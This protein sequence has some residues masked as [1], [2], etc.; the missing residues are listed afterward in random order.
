ML[1]KSVED[2]IKKYTPQFYALF[3]AQEDKKIMSNTFLLL[4]LLRCNSIMI[5][6]KAVII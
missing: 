5:L 3:N 4:W 2:Y 6:L 1:K